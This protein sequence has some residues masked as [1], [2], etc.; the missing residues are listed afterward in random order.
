[1]TFGVDLAESMPVRQVRRRQTQRIARHCERTV[2]I[3]RFAAVRLDNASLR[4]QARRTRRTHARADLDRLHSA[5]ALIDASYIAFVQSKVL[6]RDK[7]CI[8][9]HRVANQT[10][11]RLL[12][13]KRLSSQSITAHYCIIIIILT[14]DLTTTSKLRSRAMAIE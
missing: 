2:G 8:V 1:M 5:V 6:A 14:I 3:G 12:C 10:R 7:V 4:F 9:A 13:F 11:Q